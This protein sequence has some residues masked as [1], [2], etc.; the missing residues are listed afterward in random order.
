MEQA[1]KLK[2]IPFSKLKAELLKRPGCKEAYDSLEVEFKIRGALIKDRIKGLSQ[3][4]LAK[5]LNVTQAALKRFEIDG[6][7]PAFSFIQKV[8]AGLGLRLTVK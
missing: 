8:T 3:K 2:L 6:E 1:K 4:Q 5:K 7:D